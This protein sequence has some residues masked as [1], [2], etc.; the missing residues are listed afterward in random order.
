MAN[1]DR[2]FSDGEI[3]SQPDHM[4]YRQTLPQ[5]ASADGNRKTMLLGKVQNFLDVVVKCYGDIAFADTTT[6]TIKLQ[7]SSDDG[8]ADAYADVVDLYAV[9]ASG[10]ATVTN[11]TEMGRYTINTTQEL[12]WKV[13]ITTT[14]AAATGSVNVFAVG[15]NR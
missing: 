1:E 15:Q 5:N 11:G 14:D 6:T 9:T 3:R 12:Y 4:A 13:V 8:V 7:S 10:A 2:Y